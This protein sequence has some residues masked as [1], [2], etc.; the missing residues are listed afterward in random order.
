MGSQNVLRS[1]LL[2]ILCHDCFHHLYDC[3]LFPHLVFCVAVALSHSHLII[4]WLFIFFFQVFWRPSVSLLNLLGWNST[5]YS[6]VLKFL[7]FTI[8]R[9]FLFVFNF[10][11]LFFINFYTVQFFFLKILHPHLCFTFDSFLHWFWHFLHLCCLFIT[12][13]LTTWIHCWL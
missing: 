12:V 10:H 5:D 1:D 6:F 13:T 4:C 8:L 7:Y 9:S 3:R 11:I 2:K